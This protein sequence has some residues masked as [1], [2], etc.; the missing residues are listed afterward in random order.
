MRILLGVTGSGDVDEVVSRVA[1]RAL[2]VGDDLEVVVVDA[3]E[4]D[5]DVG[6]V[7]RAVHESLADRELSP[8]VHLRSGH[9]GSELVELAADGAF[10]R[11]IIEGGKRTPLGKITFTS[12]AEFVLL[13]AE[14]TVTLIR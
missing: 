2:A 10:D 5:A 3:P 6:A 8:P 13:N 12:T 4:V 14:L 1:E 9:A 7:E 11:L